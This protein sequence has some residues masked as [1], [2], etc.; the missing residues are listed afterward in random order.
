MCLP[1][2]CLPC[3]HLTN[4]PF[5]WCIF[6]DL[7]YACVNRSCVDDVN[8]S[9]RISSGGS[10]MQGS[11]HASRDGM[12]TVRG[13]SLPPSWTGNPLSGAWT[14]FSSARILANGSSK[15]R[16]ANRFCL[17]E[18]QVSFWNLA[19]CAHLLGVHF[20]AAL[21]RTGGSHGPSTTTVGQSIFNGM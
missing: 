1:R 9:P 20:S 12:R 21:E 2:F 6:W 10:E 15:A 8:R 4:Q 11:R 5:S 17:C 18:V 7:T 14:G 3:L 13:P 19:E 16:Y